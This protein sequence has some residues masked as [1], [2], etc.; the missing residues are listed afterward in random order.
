MAEGPLEDLRD[1]VRGLRV[2]ELRLEGL[3]DGGSSGREPC[4]WDG[5]RE[6]AEE[7][8][9]DS[10]LFLCRGGVPVGFEDAESL[11]SYMTGTRSSAN[12][13]PR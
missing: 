13:T 5:F 9:D 7:K 12:V 11:Q 3:R 1:V 10:G 8:G 6:G 2:I 4:A